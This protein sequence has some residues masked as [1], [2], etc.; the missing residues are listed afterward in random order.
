MSEE[1]AQLEACLKEAAES[2]S[3][4]SIEDADIPEGSQ[5]S[6]ETAIH[7]LIETLRNK[8]FFSAIAQVKAF[9]YCH[10][11]FANMPYLE[12]MQLGVSL[13]QGLM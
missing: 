12:R 5:T 7:S 1:L 10:M 6:T 2:V 11:P 4:S 3:Y 9:R 13:N 8:E